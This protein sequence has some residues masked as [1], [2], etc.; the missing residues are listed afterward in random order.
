MSNCLSNDDALKWIDGGLDRTLEPA[1][2][3][4]FEVHIDECARCRRLLADLSRLQTQPHAA[5]ENAVDPRL[6]TREFLAA[7]TLI[8]RYEVVD[9]IASG[10]IGAVYRAR[11]RELGRDVALKFIDAPIF[12]PSARGFDAEEF[13]RKEARILA[14]LNHPNVLAVH[15]IGRFQRRLFM[16]SEY[17]D[18]LD[19]RSWLRAE[20][21]SHAQI[22][23]VLQGAARGLCAAHQ[24]GI[25]HGDIKPAN[26]VV[27]RDGRVVVVDFGLA[28]LQRRLAGE[29][30]EVETFGGT[31]AYMAPEQLDGLAATRESDQFS[32]CLS[33]A[34]LLVAGPHDRPGPPPPGTMRRLP[35]TLGRALRRGLRHDPSKRFRSMGPLIDRMAPQRSLRKPLAVAAVLSILLAAYALGRRQCPVP[36]RLPAFI[37]TAAQRAEWN[38]LAATACAV[39]SPRLAC[40]ERERE[41]ERIAAASPIASHFFGFRPERCR[42]KVA[43][44]PTDHQAAQVVGSL[45]RRIDRSL[46][47]PDVQAAEQDLRSLGD[48]VQHTG[49]LPLVTEHRFAHARLL[50]ASGDPSALATLA[51]AAALAETGGTDLLRAEIAV[52]LTHAFEQASAAREAAMTRAIAEGLFDRYAFDETLRRS[53]WEATR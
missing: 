44:L 29:S 43:A 27:T 3:A 13:I 20:K 49:F 50:L 26:I 35:R 23:R 7:G 28:L 1:A 33:A 10:N 37:G 15:E 47:S 40:L 39:R 21:R 14:K 53:W 6:T 48:A 17:L 32:F 8:G 5:L 46:S 18:G 4:G 41:R 16:V 22:L 9:W 51:E 42:D 38:E 19:L 31:P 12:D 2:W 45:Q 25:I 36:T 24:A 52:V 30:G 34:E 11:D